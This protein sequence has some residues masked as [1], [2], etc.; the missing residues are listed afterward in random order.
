[1]QSPGIQ[2]RVP[3]QTQAD[4][5]EPIAVRMMA[6]LP[7]FHANNG[8]L[9]RALEIVLVRR[10]M[11]GIAFLPKTDPDILF[12][13]EPA[14]DRT[15]T[16]GTLQQV[17]EERRIGLLDFGARHD[18]AAS[19]F[20]FATFARWVSPV[21]PMEVRH[22][23]HSVG[24]GDARP[25][26]EQPPALLEALPPVPPERGVRARQSKS[27]PGHIEGILRTPFRLPLMRGDAAAPPYVSIAAVRLDDQGGV[28]AAS[29]LFDPK[30]EGT[31]FVARFSLPLSEL[32][33]PLAAAAPC[34][35]RIM[36]FSGDYQA[37]AFEIDPPESLGAAGR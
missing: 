26:R 17:S 35:L 34:R 25:V 3:L 37:P 32:G 29:F 7:V 16:G 8:I 10:D 21:H 9:D 18:G 5:P 22:P 1:M 24:P 30:T 13:P 11:P 6:D 14:L 31:D 36:V 20:V 12:V 19:Y 27:H 15:A 23:L 28:S 2:I 33:P 4:S